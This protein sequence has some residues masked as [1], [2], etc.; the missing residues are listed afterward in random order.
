MN[1]AYQ[2]D[3]RPYG[4]LEVLVQCDGIEFIGG[5]DTGRVGSS[6]SPPL[7]IGAGGIKVP[8]SNEVEVLG[9]LHRNNLK[10]KKEKK[11][12][13]KEKKSDNS[14]KRRAEVAYKVRSH[15]GNNPSDTDSGQVS[16]QHLIVTT[17]RFDVDDV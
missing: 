2:G 7:V 17:S 4:E 9:V 5:G 8:C 14:G 1:K 16:S 12:R 13:K 6:S 10:K 15:H 11:K 3:R